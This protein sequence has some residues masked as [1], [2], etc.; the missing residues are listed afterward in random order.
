VFSTGWGGDSQLPAIKGDRIMSVCVFAW[1]DG[2]GKENTI[3]QS[4]NSVRIVMGG[5]FTYG[6]T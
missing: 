5:T 4:A 2:W 3:A 6:S 1:C